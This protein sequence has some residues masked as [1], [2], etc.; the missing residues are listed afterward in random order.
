MSRDLAQVSVV[1]APWCI[2]QAEGFD[3]PVS[4]VICTQLCR[5]PF[6]V[7]FAALVVPV[8]LDAVTIVMGAI[9]NRIRKMMHKTHEVRANAVHS[10]LL[11]KC[12]VAVFSGRAPTVAAVKQY[13]C[14]STLL[15]DFL[16]KVHSW[17]SWPLSL[18]SCVLNACKYTTTDKIQN[19]PTIRAPAL[20]FAA[21]GRGAGGS[22]LHPKLHPEQVVRDVVRHA[23][24]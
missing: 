23:P 13:S 21:Q 17:W 2:W 19:A 3:V 5:L 12:L 11:R 16:R 4:Q 15:G 1:M 22:S 6:Y 24:A 9:R 18:L 20:I 7:A 8:Y 14:V 10:I